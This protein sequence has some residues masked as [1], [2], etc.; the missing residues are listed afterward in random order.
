MTIKKPTAAEFDMARAA[1]PAQHPV[2][3]ALLA[4]LEDAQAGNEIGTISDEYAHEVIRWVRRS[5]LHMAEQLQS[6]QAAMQALDFHQ[7]AKMA[8]EHQ[9]RIERMLV[10]YVILPLVA[11]A[12]FV[13]AAVAGVLFLAAR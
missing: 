12:I 6:H 11:V 2:A 5:G 3:D 9:Q 4:A 1:V 10:R 13:M 8:I 7:R